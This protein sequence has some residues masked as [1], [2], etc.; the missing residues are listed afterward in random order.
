MEVLTS[1]LV[2]E[3]SKASNRQQVPLVRCWV[4]DRC[5]GPLWPVRG[6]V[7]YKVALSS[8]AP[9]RHHGVRWA[10]CLSPY[11]GLLL[12]R[13]NLKVNRHPG[14]ARSSNPSAHLT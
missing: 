13:E 10:P 3:R 8:V 14:E 9:E 6:T 11:D 1:Y 5:L 2:Q 12:L 7:G 4:R